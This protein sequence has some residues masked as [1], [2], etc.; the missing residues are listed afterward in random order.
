MTKN[1]II[2]KENKAQV[3][4]IRE[5]ENQILS[6]EEFL[7]DYNNKEQVNYEDLTHEDI[8]LNESYGPC[9]WNNPRCLCHVSQG[10]IPLCLACPS[11]SDINPSMWFHS[12]GYLAKS[13]KNSSCGN[14]LVSGQGYIKC[15][16]CEVRGYWK[17]WKFECSKNHGYKYATSTMTFMSA[18][19]IASGFQSSEGI[20]MSIIQE[21]GIHLLRSEN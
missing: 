5:I 14:L 17:D 12:S 4:E 3:V 21:L 2:P 18:L 10:F 11:C 16:T 9:S 15:S 1:Y 20:I 7:E 19:N 13:S 8:S 6:Y